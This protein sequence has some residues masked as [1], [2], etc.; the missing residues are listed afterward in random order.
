MVN[1]VTQMDY[2]FEFLKAIYNSYPDSYRGIIHNLDKSLFMPERIFDD[3]VALVTGAGQG[4]GFA[5]AKGLAIRG[6]N[7]II[8][9][10]DASR[11]NEAARSINELGRCHAISG[12]AGDVDF[13]NTMVE[14]TIAKFGR[15]DIIVANA[16]VTLFGDFYNYTAEAFQQVMNVNLRGTFFLT[17]AAAKQMKKQ[18]AGGSILLMSSVTG[19]QAHKDLAAYGMSKAAIEMLA[20][21]LVIELSPFNISINAIAPGATI[22]ERTREDKDYEKTW[23]RITPVG[24]PANVDDITNA[25][26]FMVSPASRHITGQT[27]IIDGGWTVVSVPPK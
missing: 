23:S 13:I 17:Q 10:I 20:K 18:K 7:V 12:D 2:I 14:E 19:H 9:D 8:N 25:A 26:L 24:K 5:I 21:T 27:L 3:H 6:A 16:G 22:T 11:L 1:D 15:L 4:I